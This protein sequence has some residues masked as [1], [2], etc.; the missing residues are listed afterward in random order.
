MTPIRIVR[1]N[2][3]VPANGSV[4]AC[5]G[6]SLVTPYYVGCY[7]LFEFYLIHEDKIGNTAVP[8]LSV[9]IILTGH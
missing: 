3:T 8:W 1:L 5:E 9:V 2:R 7:R 6:G 4:K